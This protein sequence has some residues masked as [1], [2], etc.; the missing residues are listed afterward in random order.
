M[1]AHATQEHTVNMRTSAR[2]HKH[3]AGALKTGGHAHWPALLW[4]GIHVPIG[5]AAHRR[6]MM[7]TPANVPMGVGIRRTG[8]A[9]AVCRGHKVGMGGER[10]VMGVRGRNEGIGRGQILF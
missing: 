2:G 7:G 6:V 8:V 9:W 3:I 1:I 10:T 4:P 5:I